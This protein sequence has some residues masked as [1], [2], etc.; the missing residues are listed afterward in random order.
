M[1]TTPTNANKKPPLLKKDSHLY[2]ISTSFVQEHKK[3]VKNWYKSIA[4]RQR[5]HGLL[6]DKFKGRDKLLTTVSVCLTAVTSS[7]IFTSTT[8]V[9]DDI[10]AHTQKNT[11][12]LLA[13]FAGVLAAVNTIL[14]AITK[15]LQYA[16]LGE[17]H[18]IA[19][20][21]CSKL[22]FRLEDILGAH[23]EDDGKIDRERLASWLKSY[24]ELLDSAPIIPQT[25]FNERKC[26]QN[27]DI[28]WVTDE[29]VEEKDEENQ[30]FFHK[31]VR[32]LFPKK[33]RDPEIKS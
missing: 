7:A 28:S 18:K 3:P 26:D 12:Q 31:S 5:C 11:S 6:A 33:D 4:I 21:K 13:V 27:I 19:Y 1:E 23:C 15:Q 22:R 32:A 16:Q 9:N 30:N 25:T 17:Q 24:S 8:P 10:N 29:G 2:G 14:Q 20:K